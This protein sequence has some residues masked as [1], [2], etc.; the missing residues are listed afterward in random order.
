MTVKALF[1]TYVLQRPGRS[2]L[3]GHISHGKDFLS[4]KFTPAQWWCA[5]GL[6]RE[7]PDAPR[8]SEIARRDEQA[9]YV[10]ASAASA[11]AAA[12]NRGE[13]ER[14]GR[15]A[16][17]AS[18]V[19]KRGVVLGEG[20]SHGGDAESRVP[21]PAGFGGGAGAGAGV[22][23]VSRRRPCSCLRKWHSAAPSIVEEVATRTSRSAASAH[24]ARRLASAEGA[25]TGSKSTSA[26]RR[27]AVAV[28]DD[29]IPTPWTKVH[30]SVQH[31]ARGLQAPA[32]AV[33]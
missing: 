12:E 20:R 4:P 9:L 23:I 21:T 5:A 29:G 28:T 7:A 24:A 8:S 27:L 25:S 16:A 11:S 3:R 19:V 17:G 2:F 18:L 15:A 26:E 1:L 13:G 30:G 6:C 33:R 10:A 22:A 32:R 31:K 14:G